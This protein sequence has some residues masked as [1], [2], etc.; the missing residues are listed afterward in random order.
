MVLFSGDLNIIQDS[1]RK[2]SDKIA[3]DYTELEIL[4]NSQKGN[5]QFVDMAIDFVKRKLFEYFTSKKP[6][7]DVTFLGEN[8]N[9]DKL[10]SEFRYLISPLCGKINLMHAVPY[11]SISVALLKKNA[12]GQFKTICGVIDNPITQET[13][14]VEEGKGAYVNSRRIR[15]SSR[16][17]LNDAL[18]AIKNID[19]KDFIINCVK[20]Y[21]NLIM[22]NCEVLNICNVA[23]GKY[24]ATILDKQNIYQ[25]LSLLLVKEAGGLIK[26]LETGELIVSN[27]LLH[28]QF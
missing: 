25:D 8:V 18:V 4:Q 20:K 23:N 22:T 15:V 13:F 1:I 24:D 12:E 16:S 6:S 3:R 14:V 2:V 26:K 10:K 17:N 28:T 7:Y 11:F 9:N 27:D 19:N 5:I 21:N